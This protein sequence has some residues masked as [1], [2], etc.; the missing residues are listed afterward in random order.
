MV[1]HR[2]HGL[3]SGWSK[4]RTLL[5]SDPEYLWKINSVR[6]SYTRGPAYQAFRLEPGKDNILSCR[7]ETR[8][9]E[10]LKKMT[11][12]YTKR[13]NPDLESSIDTH[14]T[15]LLDLIDDKYL[16]LPG[17][18]FRPVDFSRTLGYFTLDVITD[19]AFGFPAGCVKANADVFDFFSNVAAFVP[20]MSLTAVV[21]S[22]LKITGIPWINKMLA[23]SSA[24]RVGIGKIMGLAKIAVEKRYSATESEQLDMLAAFKKHACIK[25]GLR[26]H[27]PATGYL[28]K[29]APEG[30]D[31]LPDGRH[32]PEG[33]GLAYNAWGIMRSRTV[34]GDDADLFWPERWLESDF[35]KQRAMN[36]SWELGFSSGKWRC[37]GKDIALMEINK[38]VAEFVRRY[39]IAVVN[40]G[41]P[42]DCTN[43]GL[44]L[45]RDFWFSITP[46][47]MMEDG[48]SIS[49]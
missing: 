25:E 9:L 36:R 48:I 49:G 45:V 47:G 40:P 24:D 23:P 46:R 34:F 13:E 38:V 41:K 15:E 29:Q 4:H 32:I 7:D 33:T 1:R 44:W 21:P 30:G 17:M 11:G 3:H 42:W 22:L 14:V 8:H 20:V 43:W 12:G 6:G 18:P 39:N 19:I 2:P 35:E 5:I 10:L 16:Q 28:E 27:P 31:D 26:L 37:L